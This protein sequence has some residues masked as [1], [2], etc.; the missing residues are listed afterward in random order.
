MIEWI[1][2]IGLLALIIAGYNYWKISKMDAGNQ[3]MKEIAEAIALGARSFLKAEYKIMGIFIIV[4]AVAIALFLHK[5]SGMMITTDSLL[6]AIAFVIGSLASIISGAVGMIVATKANVRTTQA[7]KKSVADAFNVAFKGGS[8]LG[9]TLVTFAMLGILTVFLI[10]QQF[11]V[12]VKIIVEAISGF[13]LGGSMMALFGRVGGGIYTKAADV[14]ADLVGKVEK[15]IPEDDPR[16]PAVIADNVGDN[17]GDIAGMG[18]DLFGSLAESTAA[19]LV[20]GVIAFGTNLGAIL[21]PLAMAAA[22]VLASIVTLFFIKVGKGKNA[23]N[24]EKPIKLSL[25]LSTVLVGIASYF[26]TNALMPATFTLHGIVYTSMGVFYALIAGLISGLLIGLVTEYYTSHTYAPVRKN[27]ESTKTGAATLMINGLALGYES[28]V[29]PVLLLA[30]TA[31]IAFHFAGLY[32]VALSALGMLGTLVIALTV[33][34]YGPISD[35]AG[36]IAEM[37]GLEKGVRQKTDILDAAGNTTAAIGKGFAIGSAA[38]TALALF[39]AFVTAAGIDSV[40]LLDFKVIGGLLVGAMLPF[41]FS[42]LTMKSVGKAA[43]GIVI[44]VRR[45]FKEIKGLMSGKGKPDYD[46][47]I[48]ISTKSALQEMILP[49]VIIIFTPVVVG[50]L[51]GVQVLAGLL[52][53]AIS[54]GVVLAISMANSGGAWDNAKKYIE[55]GHLGGKGS[56]CHKAAVIGD[57]VGDPFKD[58]SGPSLNILIKL[59]AITS[60]VLVPLF[61]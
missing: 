14:G 16:N 59:M 35:N 60:L 37:A 28:A 22:G 27:A 26:V 36:G 11:G 10:Y 58:T 4:I 5:E 31:V 19:A 46:R 43:Q 57:T 39:S 52:A 40:N 9:L 13:A 24:V 8:V 1:Y 54:A 2:L 55:A 6:T 25:V 51:F 34:V 30:F 15:G 50:L 18:S 20:I 47:C 48:A 44:E 29:V 23:N 41:I 33:D 56:D 3:K 12:D 45:Q 21:F 53:G 42:A 61:I 7:A 32:G 17:V 38:L 49:G